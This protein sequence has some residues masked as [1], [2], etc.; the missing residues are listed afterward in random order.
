MPWSLIRDFKTWGQPASGFG[1]DCRGTLL[2]DTREC[3]SKQKDQM[4]PQNQGI[5]LTKNMRETHIA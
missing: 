3:K 1:T 2:D 4:L 5:K